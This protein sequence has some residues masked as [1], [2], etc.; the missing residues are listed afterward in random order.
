[1]D[2][3]DEE[4]DVWKTMIHIIQSLRLPSASDA[5]RRTIQRWKFIV[6][7]HWDVILVSRQMQQRYSSEDLF[8]TRTRNYYVQRLET[9]R[10]ELI[11]LDHM[12]TCDKELEIR[13]CNLTDYNL[14]RHW[15]ELL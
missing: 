4:E 6:N 14:W 1:M 12:K 15:K 7:T 3:D 11:V 13:Y 9:K 5:I 2:E 8:E 10:I